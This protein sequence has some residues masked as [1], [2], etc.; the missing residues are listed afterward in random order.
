ME[1]FSY[2]RKY[3]KDRGVFVINGRDYTNHCHRF[4]AIAIRTAMDAKKIVDGPKILE[5]S[6][7]DSMRKVFTEMFQAQNADTLQKKIELVTSYYSWAGLG[8][9]SFDAVSENGGEVTLSSSHADE[10]WKLMIGK[11]TE[12][13]NFITKGFIGAA[14]GC[15]YDKVERSYVV[16]EVESIVLGNEKSTFKIYLP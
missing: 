14:F 2:D 6:V 7:E 5:T 1:K 15:F 16:N 10:A 8:V 13:I 4:I 9:I 12:P 3:D 11:A